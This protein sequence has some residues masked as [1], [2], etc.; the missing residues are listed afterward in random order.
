MASCNYCQYQNTKLAAE[1]AGGTVELKPRPA[2]WA[3]DGVDIFIRYSESNTPA[4][5]TWLMKLPDHCVC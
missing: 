5:A 3:P 2:S 4:W 1:K